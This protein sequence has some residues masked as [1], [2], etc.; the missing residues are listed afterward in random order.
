MPRPR[1]RRFL[2]A[3]TEM[4]KSKIGRR[5]IG[6]AVPWLFPDSGALE[7]SHLA[8]PSKGRARKRLWVLPDAETARL[9]AGAKILVVTRV[10]REMWNATH[11]HCMQFH[12]PALI[13]SREG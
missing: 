4:S 10:N 11:A 5:L 8:G 13:L 2:S 3:V 7:F 12:A 9:T 6:G 1:A